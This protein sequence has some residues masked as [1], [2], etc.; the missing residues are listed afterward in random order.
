MLTGAPAEPNLKYSTAMPLGVASPDKVDTRFGTLNFFD[1]LP[2]G[3]SYQCRTPLSI[4][5]PERRRRRYPPNAPRATEVSTVLDGR[6]LIS[7]YVR[8]AHKNG[9]HLVLTALLLVV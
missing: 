9:H 4:R 6:G 2:T 7:D 3:F 5:L 1:G 8:D